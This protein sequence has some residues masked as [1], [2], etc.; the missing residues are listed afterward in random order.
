MKNILIITPFFAPY[1]H[2]AVYR[3]HRFAKYL[4]RFG[5]KPYVL[6]VDRDFLYFVDSL[7]LDDLPKDVQII[8]AR[9]APLT[10]SGF[11][12]L[13]SKPVN[14]S[15]LVKGPAIS[16]LFIEAQ[17][18]FKRSLIRNIFY[19]LNISFF[20][21][22]DRYNT[23]YPFALEK[24]KKLIN[25]NDIRIIYSTSPPFTSHLIA[26]RLKE[27]YNI[28]WVAD[29]RD[30]GVERDRIDL[31]FS[32][33][34]LNYKINCAIEQKTIEKADLILTTAESLQDLF[35]SKYK[36]IVKNKIIYLGHGADIDILKEVNVE[37]V[38]KDNKK[39]TIIYTGEF[40]PI[41]NTK[42]FEFLNIIFERKLFKR[43]NVEVLIIGNIKRNIFLQKEIMQL[44]LTD[45]VR[46]INYLSLKEYFKALLSADA[47]FLPTSFK[48]RFNIKLAEYLS[49]KKPIIVF[50]ITDEVQHVLE[51]SGLGVFISDDP[52]EGIKT[53]LNLLEGNNTFKINEDYINKFS[54]FNRTME[55]ADLLTKLEKGH[56]SD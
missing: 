7:L 22:P 28:P 40:L 55:L 41:Y 52:K 1:S 27:K 26:M 51:K 6:T 48:Y 45:V 32:F 16:D 23:W 13:F 3:A 11:K 20:F 4:P 10:F 56:E 43:E 2:A 19:K 5:W 36:G 25:N 49:I 33:T 18:S 46:L 31:E 50:D 21:M 35:F 8:R 39:F 14:D 24:A 29:F 30:P 42:L 44:G 38:K 15:R 34:G 53:L 12:S 17:K 47:T 37:L 9:Y 54:S